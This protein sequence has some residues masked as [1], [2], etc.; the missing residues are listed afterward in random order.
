MKQ[1]IYL[2]IYLMTVY[3]IFKPIKLHK[4]YFFILWYIALILLTYAIQSVVGNYD[5]D[6]EK[7][8][9]LFQLEDFVWTPQYVREP[10]F[11]FLGRFVYSI[12]NDR[13]ITFFILN[14]M[15]AVVLYKGFTSNLNWISKKND[16]TVG[17]VLF[18]Y[19]LFFP[20][21]VGMHALYR[22]FFSMALFICA[23][24]YAG[25]HKLFKASV[26]F[27]FSVLFHNMAILFTPLFVFA[28][29][30]ARSG[31]IIVLNLLILPFALQM[32]ESSDNEF[33]VRHSINYL[34]YLAIA[35]FVVLCFIL[36]VM[37]APNL[38]GKSNKDTVRLKYFMLLLTLIYLISFFSID[39]NLTIE[40]VGIYCFGITFFL[41]GCYMEYF[42]QKNA[43][44]LFFFHLSLIPLLTFYNS[45]LQ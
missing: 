15:L 34:P 40:R 30:R 41:L 21:L 37:F 10:L 12:V 5:T 14:S 3:L 19:L 42:S 26:L 36:V 33:L 17:Y 45:L 25:N 31:W 9:L 29:R 6:L 11:W 39:S 2:S 16:D 13:N 1:S 32:T 4:K 23:V 18:G 7:Y 20:F 43:F 35:F 24:G 28:L 22:Q 8:M 27:L 38:A 44:K